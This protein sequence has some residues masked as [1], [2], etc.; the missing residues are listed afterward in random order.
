ML[1]NDDVWPLRLKPERRC[2][3]PSISN[4]FHLYVFCSYFGHCLFLEMDYLNDIRALLFANI[5]ICC[6]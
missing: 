2:V 4:G 1:A 6:V 3:D 5:C